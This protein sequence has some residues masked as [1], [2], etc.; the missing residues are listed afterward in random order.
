MCGIIG[1][2][3]KRPVVPILLDGLRRLEY[4]GYDSAGI[5]FHDNGRL[6]V[7][8]CPGKV[9]D[10]VKMV[11]SEKAITNDE[12][13]TTSGQV[14]IGHT[15][16]A[17][18]G[19]PTATNAHPHLDCCGQIAVVHNGIIEN[20]Q[21]LK[22]ALLA[23]GHR[24]CSQTDTE[25][26]PHL[27]EESLRLAR[28]QVAASLGRWEAPPDEPGR[29]F[30]AE[31]GADRGELLR[32]AV[33]EAV[34]Q[35]EG[36]FAIAVIF[37]WDR[38]RIF[39]A[40]RH[41]P[42]IVGIGQGE[43]FLASDIPALLPYT[44]EVVALSDD[45]L[46]LLEEEGIDIF[47]TA[48]GQ[49]LTRQPTTVN[50]D[51]SQ[52]EKGGYPH[53]MLKEI[54]EQPDA[55]RETVRGRVLADHGQVVL[56]EVPDR[57]LKR[58]RRICIVACGT[59]YHAG[60]VG[61]Y[62]IEALAGIPVEVDIASEFRYREGDLGSGTLLLAI[63]QS[64]E[65][66]D[67][68]AAVES[69]VRKEKRVASHLSLVPSGKIDVRDQRRVTGD[70]KNDRRL[71]T[72]AI[73]NVVGSSLTRVSDGVIY[74]RAGPE[75]GVASTKTFTAQLVAL[76]LL[77]LR[78]RQARGRIDAAQCKAAIEELLRLPE[79]MREVLA[80]TERIKT[81]AERLMDR[82]DF[83]YIGRSVSYPIALEG[84]LKLKEIAYINAQG[85]AAG[86]MKHGPIALIESGFP[87]I[88]IAPRDRVYEKMLG[89]IE[90]ARA[91]KAFVVAL[92]SQGDHDIASKAD[93]VIYLPDTHPLLTPILSVLPLQLLAYYIAV[94][95]GCDVDQPRNLAKSVTVE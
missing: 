38:Q 21:S 54:H 79:A 23:R 53:F 57:L 36:S 83:I 5:A 64:G 47:T 84:A 32:E 73:T 63:S 70:P 40:R 39:A 31:D 74:T 37:G 12:R 11:V 16:W 33:R 90:E 91:R 65:T 18:H 94:L 89:N 75:I 86:E 50:W 25:V 67:T 41:C 82:R 20:Y 49:R 95:K 8:K 92:A 61:R 15:R 56:E 93:E 2:V 29:F 6:S 42:L 22:A 59:S 17:T 30:D 80:G 19:E 26:I 1:Y 52:A 78:L 9:A 60:L 81:L 4:R 28:R 10:L 69:L 88:A 14:G 76:F 68:L 87:V 35:L 85:Y 46:A 45:E 3:G 58:L 7:I 55:V 34:R 44:K 48:R 72:L 62:M 71:T 27:I 24:F 77:A 43:Y 51:A 66:A 13:R